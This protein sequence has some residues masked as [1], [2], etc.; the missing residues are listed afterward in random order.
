M[1][2]LNRLN[3]DLLARVE[4][5]GE[6]FLSN[7]VVD[8]KFALRACIVNFNTTDEDVDALPALVARHAAKFRAHCLTAQ[9]DSFSG[10]LLCRA[11]ATAA[12]DDGDLIG[13][14]RPVR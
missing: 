13:P 11:S 8:G 5:S 4:K 3:Q 9:E 6:A 2:R 7:A 10:L 12:S 1:E 14:E